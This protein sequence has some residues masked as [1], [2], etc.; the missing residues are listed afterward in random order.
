MTGIGHPMLF[1]HLG[2]T[3]PGA[4]RSAEELVLVFDVAPALEDF[5]LMQTD[6]L[7]IGT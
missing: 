6:L 2:Q 4:V 5:H 1:D 3:G 7:P